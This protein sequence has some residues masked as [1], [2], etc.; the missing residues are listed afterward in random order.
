MFHGN[1]YV[2]INM[3]QHSGLESIK[4]VR[5]GCETHHVMSV[6]FSAGLPA[7]FRGYI[8]TL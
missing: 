8:R 2:N 4:I 1:V 6:A 5:S 3:S 7:P